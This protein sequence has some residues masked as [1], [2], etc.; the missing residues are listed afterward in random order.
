MY[1]H[2]SDSAGP[3]DSR[4]VAFNLAR[5]TL[6]ALAWM[7]WGLLLGAAFLFV[8]RRLAGALDTASPPAELLPTAFLV[9]VLAAGTGR[10]LGRRGPASSRLVVSLG[11]T[12]A[13]L[14][15]GGAWTLPG[16]SAALLVAMW[17]VLLIGVADVWVPW[18]PALNL[19]GTTPSARAELGQSP[20]DRGTPPIDE[21]G[22]IEQ[23]LTRH[24]ADGG[25]EIVRGW[26][27]V[28]LDVGQRTSNAHVAFCPPLPRVPRLEL[29]QISGPSARIKVGQVLAYGA[30]LDLKLNAPAESEEPIRVSFRAVCSPSTAES[31]D[32][33]LD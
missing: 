26:L 19:A 22:P 15:L 9:A 17:L 4:Y 7:L 3:L 6:P 25:V 30:R 21:D 1:A 13:L 33:Q 20:L 18:I 32:R 12:V 10:M 27:M 11:A 2:A 24:R 14:A 8:A 23:E 29:E 28:P 16:T 31:R 5:A